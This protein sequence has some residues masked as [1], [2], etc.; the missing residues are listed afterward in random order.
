MR[1][2]ARFKFTALDEFIEEANLLCA[3]HG[4]SMEYVL[5]EWTAVTGPMCV[6]TCTVGILFEQVLSDK[7]KVYTLGIQ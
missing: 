2:I 5:I 1:E 3:I 7:S 6:R 4:I